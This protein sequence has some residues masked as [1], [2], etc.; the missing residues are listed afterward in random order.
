MRGL[1]VGTKLAYIALK[2][3][4]MQKKGGENFK[5]TQHPQGGGLLPWASPPSVRA[6]AALPMI[7][8]LTR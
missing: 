8:P 2:E 7:V 4:P 6:A 1:L 3:R 5:L